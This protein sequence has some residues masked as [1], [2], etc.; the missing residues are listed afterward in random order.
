[1][2]LETQFK[3][4]LEVFAFQ[5]NNNLIF[6]FLLTTFSFSFYIPGCGFSYF[7]NSNIL[8]PT[9]CSTFKYINNFII[10][11]T[12]R[13]AEFLD[14]LYMMNMVLLNI[15]LALEWKFEP[16]FITEIKNNEIINIVFKLNSI[17]IFTVFILG[18]FSTGYKFSIRIKYNKLIFK[19]FP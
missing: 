9:N 17:F 15:I 5:C 11:W 10:F 1:M 8:K 3:Y 18:A 14:I 12:S 2:T 7:W 19:M 16:R 6:Q 13:N 4:L